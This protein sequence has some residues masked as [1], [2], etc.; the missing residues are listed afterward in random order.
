VR[1]R[2]G[3]CGFGIDR[4]EE[5][6]QHCSAHFSNEPATAATATATIASSNLSTLDQIVHLLPST[7][8]D[9]LHR[10]VPSSIIPLILPRPSVHSVPSFSFHIPLLVVVAAVACPVSY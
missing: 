10:H 7:S 5:L 4:L 3:K 2:V 1:E 6:D 9:I 8:S